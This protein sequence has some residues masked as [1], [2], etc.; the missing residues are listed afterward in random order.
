LCWLLLSVV[1]A[2]VVAAP[3]AAAGSS[4][5]YKRCR[6]AGVEL[7]V[8]TADLNDPRVVVKPALARNGVGRDESFGSFISRLQP[9]AA[10]NGT[11][12]SKRSLRPVGDIVVDGKLVHFG[13]MGTAIAF[14]DD[15]VSF[16]R[17]PKSRRVDWSGHR[18]ALASGPL[19]VWDGFAKPLPGGEGF[20]DPHVFA[21]AAPRSAI[22]VTAN[23]KLLLTT[24]V[25]G[26]S[27]SQLAKAMRAL[28]AVYAVNLD[29]GSSTAMWHQGRSIRA[30]RRKL[31]NVLCVFV[32]PAAPERPP[33]RAP[34]G[35]DWRR[36]HAKPPLPPVMAFG[37]ADVRISVE[38]PREWAGEEPL[39]LRSDRPL[40][41]GA[42][43]SVKM[44]ERPVCLLGSLPAEVKV[45]VDPTLRPKHKLWV[46]VLDAEGRVLGS[47]HRILQLPGFVPG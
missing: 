25:Q 30:P 9:T 27:L 17:L 33:L 16:I 15:G 7:H 21:Q 12:F 40:P 13:G 34:V 39:R 32:L 37:A 18:A 36:G 2:W 20:G 24:T 47:A 38:L 5:D 43:V 14:A 1:G 19:L 29:G 28:G 6:V 10:I 3:R 35:L 41:E 46:G 44:D 31:T 11:F 45:T 22:G 42:A 8:V 23:N 26:T 4:L